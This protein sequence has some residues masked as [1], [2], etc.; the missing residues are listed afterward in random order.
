MV[1]DIVETLQYAIAFYFDPKLAEDWCNLLCIILNP[2]LPGHPA[3]AEPFKPWSCLT[4][5]FN[6]FWVK[7]GGDFVQEDPT[8]KIK[9][10]MR[11]GEK[12]LKEE[13]VLLYDLD[14]SNLTTQPFQISSLTS[15]VKKAHYMY[16]LVGAP[17]PSSAAQNLRLPST[18]ADAI[19]QQLGYWLQRPADGVTIDENGHP[20]YMLDFWRSQEDCLLRRVAL[21][22]GAF[23]ISQ[24]VT[25]RVNE[26]PK[27][28]WTSDRRSSL[29]ESI[30]RDV[31]YYSCEW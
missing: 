30:N 18:K 20:H 19:W 3:I 1:K 7:N 21:R 24:C 8:L 10:V 4:G 13:F 9:E 15:T 11:A 27:E 16:D 26:I 5:R 28:L 31:L 17:H 29:V 2:C 14:H 6:H 23:L 25:G 12:V 22:A